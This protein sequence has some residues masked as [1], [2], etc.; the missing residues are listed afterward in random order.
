LPPVEGRAFSNR[1]FDFMNDLKAGKVEDPFNW[2]LK[3]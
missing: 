3:V 1:V 2:T